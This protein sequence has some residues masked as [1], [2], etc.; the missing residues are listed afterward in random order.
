MGLGFPP[1]WR[2]RGANFPFCV[3]DGLSLR[4]SYNMK[5]LV[6]P[7]WRRTMRLVIG[8]SGWQI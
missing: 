6:F 7:H 3:L 5:R 8:K 2:V 4:R 1:V